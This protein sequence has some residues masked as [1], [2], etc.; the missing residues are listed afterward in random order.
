M[1]QSF[2]FYF[3]TP[4]KKIIQGRMK[5]DWD[6]S[7][8]TLAAS[9]RFGLWSSEPWTQVLSTSLSLS[10]ASHVHNYI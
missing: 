2:A 1:W 5:I 3:L 9:W 4:S 7:F 6:E 8:V 10:H